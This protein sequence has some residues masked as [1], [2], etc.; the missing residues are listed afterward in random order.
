MVS[1]F[2]SNP[3]PLECHTALTIEERATKLAEEDT[4]HSQVAKTG[5]E[6]G[7]MSHCI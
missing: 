5:M 7:N 6:A 2:L 4:C 3:F 1:I